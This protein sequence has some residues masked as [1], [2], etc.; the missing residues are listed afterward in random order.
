MGRVGLLYV[1]IGDC[2]LYVVWLW[3]VW[4]EIRIECFGLGGVGW[5]G[6]LCDLV[7]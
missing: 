7:D 6:V 5:F 2:V 1:D 3:V 4:F